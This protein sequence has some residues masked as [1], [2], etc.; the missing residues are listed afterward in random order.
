MN[1]HTKNLL[2]PIAIAIAALI[3]SGVAVWNVSNPT[4]IQQLGVT[5]L[6]SLHLSD[7]GG[8]ATP[9]LLVNQDGT[10]V[11]AEFRDAGTPIAQFLDGG[12]FVSDGGLDLNGK[13]LT[14]DADTDTTLKAPVDD[15]ITI[16]LG[17]ATGRLDLLTGNLKVGNGTATLTQNGED[18]YVEGTFEV[19]GQTQLDGGLDLNASTLTIDADADTTMVASVDDI[20][21]LTLGAATGRLDFL[22]GNLKIGNGT[23]NTT[24]NGEDAYIEGTLEVDGTADL[25]GS[26]DAAADVDVGT[27][28]NLSAQ[29][30]VVVTAGSSITPT[31]TYQPITSTA[32]VTTSTST[33]ILNGGETGDLLA[34]RNANAAD[35]ITIDGVG[36]NVECKTDKVL[37]AGDTLSLIWNGSDW[38]CL[39]TFDNS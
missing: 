37:G 3:L 38:N 25:D 15:I 17:A 18:V 12:S 4:E 2:W 7:N 26:V 11:I 27:W 28:V 8:T 34:L 24:L 1:N 30:A 23:N 19:D 31:G 10:G 39:A 35:N 13:T 14:I 20:I 6:D 36:S 5:N 16:T 33:A 21:T 29:T 9:V 22:T 32:W